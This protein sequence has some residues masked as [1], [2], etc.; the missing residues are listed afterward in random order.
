MSPGIVLPY[1][2]PALRD[3]VVAL[4]PWSDR[5]LACVEEASR[6]PDIPPGTTV[7]GIY[8][9]AEGGAFVRRQRR[10]RLDGR[11]VSLVIADPATDRAVGAAILSLR[12]DP[13]IAALGYWIVSSARRNGYATHAVTLLARWGVTAGGRARIEAHIEPANRASIAVAE[14]AG[15]RH[16]GLLRAYLEIGAGRADVLVYS[17]LPKDV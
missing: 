4:R 9:P 17:L 1:P 3:D 13:G 15:M 14:A 10:R 2:D 16:E 8:T 6:D 12:P 11:G 5:D 7:P